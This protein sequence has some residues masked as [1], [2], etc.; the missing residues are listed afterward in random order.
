M[1]TFEE[2]QAAEEARAAEAKATTEEEAPDVRRLRQEVSRLQRKLSDSRGGTDIIVDAVRQA[3]ENVP[4]DLELAKRPRRSRAKSKEIAVLHVSDVQYGK[5][6]SSYSSAIA[7][8]RLAMLAERVIQ[9]TEMRRTSVAVDELRVY[10]G[11]DLVEGEMIFPGQAHSIDQGVYDQAVMGLPQALARMLLRLAEAFPAVRVVS[12]VGNHGRPGRKG[13]GHPR[14]NWDRVTSQVTRLVVEAA[15]RT[16]RDRIEFEIP[17]TFY[18]VDRVHEWGNL[19]VHGDQIRG[20]FAGFPW[21]GCVPDDHEILTRSGWRGVDDLIIGEDVLTLDPETHESRWEP[22]Q[23]VTT[24]E[25]DDDVFRLSRPGG[26]EILC[27]RDHSWPTYRGSSPDRRGLVKAFELNSNQWLPLHGDF[28]GQ[29]STLSP[30]HAAILGW[31]VTDGHGRWTGNH[32]EAVVYQSARKHLEAV[33]E[34]LGNER[35]PLAPSQVATA[36]DVHAVPV[37]IE[38]AQEITR[39]YRTKGDLP[40]VVGR[41]SREAA[42]AMFDAMLAAEASTCGRSVSFAQKPGP[43]A[44]AFHMLSVLVG[45]TAWPTVDSE[46]MV[47][48]VPRIGAGVRP[49]WGGGLETVRFKGRVWCPTTPSGTWWVRGRGGMTMPTGNTAKKAW[50]WID[51][52]PE[53]WDYLWIGHFH[54]YAETV[55]N[56]R[57]CLANGTT[58]SDNEYAQEQLAAGGDPVQRFAFFS[59]SKGRVADH[60]IYLIDRTPAKRTA[61]AWLS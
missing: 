35:R 27:T 42:E 61:E 46:G 18:A 47:R 16:E 29:E 12:V 3:I 41:L 32:W 15:L 44:E 59:R 2:F 49:S 45:R 6:T 19:I 54:T 34:L 57:V 38:D 37:S 17:D 7:D 1:T 20:G 31:V 26:H 30:R 5:T 24:Y 23:D 21:Y 50:G 43:V 11:G 33:E 52:I 13:E 25:I 8:A 14:T 51:T 28:R 53:P 58:E 55:L 60:P 4:V 22:V 56:R 48:A 9:L 10:L 39:A 40:R 36:E